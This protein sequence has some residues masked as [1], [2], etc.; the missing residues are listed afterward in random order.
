MTQTKY[1][2]KSK[3]IKMIFNRDMKDNAFEYWQEQMTYAASLGENYEAQIVPCGVCP[4]C[5]LQ[6]SREWATRC[7]MEA[8]QW[9]SNY[10]VTLTYDDE[11]KPY[12][13]QFEFNGEI[14]ED[15]TT[16][17]GYLDKKDVQLFIKRLRTYYFREHGHTGIRFFMCG[18]YGSQTKRPHYHIIFFNLPIYDWEDLK[19]TSNGKVLATSR[20]IRELWGK[21]H[22]SIG[23]VEFASAAYVARYAMK[24]RTGRYAQKHYAERGQTPEFVN[25]SR[26][27]G[28]GKEW[29]DTHKEEI[30]ELDDILSSELGK[31]K[32]KPPRYFDKL[33]DIDYPEDMKRIKKSRKE[34]GERSR[35][36][37]MSKTTATIKQQFMFENGGKT[38]CQIWTREPNIKL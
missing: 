36:L 3:T 15:D 29:Y 23:E 19:V 20:T 30:Y 24:K 10:F 27:P 28:I 5:R 38:S 8:K 4:S 33:Y 35:K 37:T 6:Q 16:W 22:V 31:L 7:M 17:N 18:E 1:G 13:E 12:N 21:G 11:H 34:A 2:G 14:Y 9:E 26:R 25:M 32:G